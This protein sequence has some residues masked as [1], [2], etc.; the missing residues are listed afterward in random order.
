MLCMEGCIRV[1]GPWFAPMGMGRQ[2][3]SDDGETW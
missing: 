2:G 1:V 3:I